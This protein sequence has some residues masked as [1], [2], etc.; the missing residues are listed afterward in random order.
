MKNIIFYLLI[1]S[2]LLGAYE[3]LV[4][5]DGQEMKSTNLGVTNMNDFN[6]SGC[7]HSVWS[8]NYN[9]FKW[10]V[11]SPTTDYITLKTADGSIDEL[12]S[13]NANEGFWVVTHDGQSCDV[14]ITTVNDTTITSIK[15]VAGWS[16]R[17]SKKEYTDLSDFDK[18]TIYIIWSY[19]RETSK[20]AA[21]SPNP[22]V[23]QQ[24]S[25]NADI[26]T[27]TSLKAQEGFWIYTTDLTTI[28]LPNVAP[29]AN[30]GPDQRVSVTSSVMLDA[31]DSSDANLNELSY[32]WSL[33][34]KPIGSTATLSKTT[35]IK[36][37]FTADKAGIYTFELIVNDG[38]ENSVKDTILVTA[39][40]TEFVYESAQGW[41]IG[42]YI[43]SGLE[44]INSTITLADGTY[45]IYVEIA[46]GDPDVKAV[47]GALM[48]ENGTDISST[49]LVGNGSLE[50]IVNSPA[51]ITIKNSSGASKTYI[52]PLSARLLEN[53]NMVADDI[54]ISIVNEITNS[55]PRGGDLTLGD[56]DTN[57]LMM[58]GVNESHTWSF[59]A[60]TSGT[61]TLDVTT[62]ETINKLM[63]FN[64]ELVQNG[65][66][67]ELVN[68]NTEI[69]SYTREKIILEAGVSYIVNISTVAM[70]WDTIGKYTIKLI[71]D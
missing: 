65:N 69:G 66:G 64:I 36:P 25:D 58:L 60:D 57:S 11:Y 18:N 19:D 14:N 22:D 35:A 34:S 17:G 7:I 46:D 12:V 23:A 44:P 30:A 24:I 70:Q 37:I 40:K 5:K 2:T 42:N 13:L 52:I 26:A 45:K 41:G 4:I 32:S 27:L 59:T 56:V 68:D 29:V 6:N 49:D 16:I 15:T 63:Q 67:S 8:Y 43:S 10:E 20:W 1:I 9:S 53:N 31:E 38:E 50:T 71:K 39:I 21:Y 33:V 47:I 48:D 61:Y 54:H 51:N 62:D 28:D 3:T 55:Y